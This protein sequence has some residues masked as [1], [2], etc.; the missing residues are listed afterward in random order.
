MVETDLK[1]PGA[2]TFGR[3]VG[4][5]VV[6]ARIGTL[7][8]TNRIEFA[9]QSVLNVTSHLNALGFDPL[10]ITRIGN[11][12]EGR[13][14][15]RLL[16]SAGVST[17]AIQIDGSLPTFDRVSRRQ[18]SDEPRCAWQALQP[19][20]AVEAIQSD[21]TSLVYHGATAAES[22]PIQE[23]LNTIQTRTGMP[24]FVDVDLDRRSLPIHTV[25]RA[26]LGVTWVRTEAD[27]LPVLNEHPSNG[28]HSILSEARALQARFA[29]EGVVAERHGLPLVAVCGDRT[30]LSAVSLPADTTFLPGGRDAAAAALIAGVVLGWSEDVMIERAV[31]FACL[32][33]GSA[34]ARGVDPNI[35]TIVQRHWQ[36][37]EVNAARS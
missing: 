2:M 10:L 4:K 34:L 17:C 26:L 31:Q 11:D 18:R 25:R 28:R 24:F 32:A 19:K 16:E 12:I 15:L 8:P 21:T 13:Q 36:S 23:V 27:L 33:G 35:Y 5:P 30:A 9:G 14:V 22:E 6:V 20:P 37:R 29:L 1:P 7:P 3:G